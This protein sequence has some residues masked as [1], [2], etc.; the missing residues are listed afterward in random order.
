M[1]DE[2]SYRSMTW[3]LRYAS[4]L[5][6]RSSEEPLFRDSIGSLDPV[7]HVEFAAAL[8][9]SGV[10]YA[11]A[12]AR[13]R[14]EQQAV[15]AAMARL[16]LETGC[17][18]YT[19][20]DNIRRP[21]W[22][23]AGPEARAWLAAELARAFDAVRR[24][25]SRYLAVLSGSDP[26]KDAT[27][28]RSAFIDNLRWASE[29]AEKVGLVLLLESVDRNRLP[30]MLL[31]HIA[32][33]HD[34]VAAVDSPAVRLIFDTAHIQAMDGNLVA[35]LEATWN[36][37][38]VVQLADMPGRLE[39]GTGEIDFPAVLGLLKRRGFKG[40]V[41]LEFNWSAPGRAAEQAGI[42][43]LRKLDAAA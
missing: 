40:L 1:E 11:L 31:H 2:W 42:D 6:Y 20:F 7:A 18:I 36:S 28:Q 19:T 4:H 29:R 33:A 34:V 25:G 41:E 16:G 30:D 38:A 21:L 43:R 3:R 37:I 13:S 23:D 27:S 8:G 12:L 9:L 26:H 22:S 35:H 14:A 5:G 10:Q 32:A 39:P 24:V 15:G 17:V